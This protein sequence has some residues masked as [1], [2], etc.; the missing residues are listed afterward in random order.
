MG[1][2]DGCS[3]QRPAEDE[4]VECLDESDLEEAISGKAI[5]FTSDSLGP[6]V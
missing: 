2:D 6:T 1:K 5:Y 3:N 4:S